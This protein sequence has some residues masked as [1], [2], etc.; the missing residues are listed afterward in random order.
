MGNFV[1]GERKTSADSTTLWDLLVDVPGWPAAFTPHLKEAHIEGAVAPGVTG[2]VK[3]RL[4]LPRA[5]FRVTR[6]EAGESWAWQG[7][8][9]WLTMDF[10]HR[11]SQVDKGSVVMF[12]VDLVGPL[13]WALRP[14]AR[15][16]YR[17]Q[18]ERALDLLVAEAEVRS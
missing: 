6:V 2:W 7:K 14:L 10:D 15:L 11:L 9:L 13:G 12:D 1:T 4:P 16:V 8:L 17:P 3:T 5:A 18:M